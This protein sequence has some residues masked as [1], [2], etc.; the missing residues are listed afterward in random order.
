MQAMSDVGSLLLVAAGLVLA[1]LAGLFLFQS[2]G[3]AVA[4]PPAL[5]L[6]E[7]RIVDC[8][9]SNPLAVRAPLPSSYTP[10][11]TP[12]EVV[13]NSAWDGSVWQVDEWLRS[14]LKDPHSLE[15]IEWSPVTKSAGGGFMV[16]VKYRAKNSLGGY[17]IDNKG[18]MLDSSGA[19]TTSFDWTSDALQL[20]PRC[21][22]VM[23]KIVVGISATRESVKETIQTIIHD[24]TTSDPDL[25]VITLFLYSTEDRALGLYD[26]ARA[27][28][29][30]DGI[31][32]DTT[33]EVAVSNDR[34]GYVLSVDIREDLESYL[35]SISTNET[36][37]G[38]DERT[39][40]A[41]FKAETVCEDASSWE[42]YKRYNDWCSRCQQFIK[43]D[44]RLMIAY[45]VAY[46][47]DCKARLMQKYGITSDVLDA[48]LL[49][50]LEKS[51]PMST[52][53]PPPACCG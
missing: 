6:G 33:S 19:V 47:T 29:S 45:V 9:D 24:K 23:C 8:E 46:E 3:G 2:L 25:D 1:V 49:E 18:F 16:R 28:W 14:N 27:L 30:P 41:I 21:K 7:F 39:R 37:N 52:P 11:E 44:E 17:V 4:E 13:Y 53:I 35:A 12:R 50:G 48:L 22:R 31:A 42:A 26:V 36:L 40:R 5:E 20:L 38:L 15:Y 43:D 32:Y 51:W 10:T 34:T